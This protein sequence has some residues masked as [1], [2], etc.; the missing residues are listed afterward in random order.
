M[1]PF[2]SFLS[3]LRPT[4]LAVLFAVLV[5]LG[6]GLWQWNQPPKPQPRAV[7]EKLGDAASLQVE[8]SPNG[9]NLATVHHYELHKCDFYHLT[10]WDAQTGR[11]KLD[12]F[13]GPSALMNSADREQKFLFIWG[14]VFSPDGQK[15]ACLF[16][17]PLAGEF[18]EG[19]IHVWDVTSG[20]KL[21]TFQEKVSSAQLAFSP[22]GT[23]LALRHDFL[24]DVA[25]NKKVK[26][27]LLEGEEVIARHGNTIVVRSQGAGIKVWDLST[28]TLIDENLD[29]RDR[30]NFKTGLLERSMYL[31]SD[32]F[33]LTYN[34]IKQEGFIFDLIKRQEFPATT[35]TMAIS[36]DGR[37]IALAQHTP[38]LRQKSWWS[39]SMDW[40][41]IQEEN[42]PDGIVTLNSFPSG[43]EITVLNGCES[44]KWRPKFSPDGKTLAVTGTDGSLQLWDLPIRKPIA[45][46]LAY[47]G[48]AALVTL[49][50]FKGLGWLRRRRAKK[51]AQLIASGS[52]AQVPMVETK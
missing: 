33:F 20:K 50:A 14:L 16:Q 8:F 21:A 41:G 29:I 52:A 22:Q 32:R 4:R 25:D 11:K 6:V 26:E 17:E 46:I 27:I 1:P 23:L 15:L 42:R 3:A 13:E 2:R 34:P 12:F 30:W 47:A 43:E 19:R 28:A 5:G 35:A 7:L 31:V 37:T 45:K 48:L 18:I 51:H 9:Q 24:W 39:R 44:P 10:L 40:I 49:L 36:P 38:K